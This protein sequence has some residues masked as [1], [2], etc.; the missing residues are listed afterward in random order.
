LGQGA[1][2]TPLTL[3]MIKGDFVVTGPDIEPVKFKSRRE[4]RG[5][6]H[7]ETPGEANGAGADRVFAGGRGRWLGSRE[8]R[9]GSGKVQPIRSMRTQAI[10]AQIPK[11]VASMRVPGKMS[12]M[13]S[14]LPERR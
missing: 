1:P 3:R 6:V 4:A 8:E 9:G 2:M 5:L 12:A 13:A 10:P 7:Q 11:V 14:F